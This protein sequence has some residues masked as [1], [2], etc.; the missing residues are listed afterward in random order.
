MLIFP[1]LSSFNVKNLGTLT[2]VA[3][4]SLAFLFKIYFILRKVKDYFFQKSFRFTLKLRGM[5]KD[6]PYIP[7]P[8]TCIFYHTVFPLP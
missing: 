7:Y 3:L 5:Y 8:Y 2:L 4:S 1:V 6:F